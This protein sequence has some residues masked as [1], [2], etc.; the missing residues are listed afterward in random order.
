MTR[1]E[2]DSRGRLEMA[3]LTLYLERGFDHT[4]VAEIAE[5]AGVTE[6]T[7]FRHFADKREVLFSGGATFLTLITSGAA[8]ADEELGPLDAALNGFESV[9]AF[10]Q[11]RRELVLQRH[12][13]IAAN[14]E[15]RE[16]EL[17]KLQALSIAL[18]DT[19]RGRGV[20]ESSAGLIAE[21]AVA[22][23]KS[24][25]EVWVAD[26]ESRELTQ[27]LRQ[28]LSELRSLAAIR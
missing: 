28:S 13:V 14:A 17:I 25:F 16:R 27:V 21:V 9:S 19:L 6:R 8:A 23:F 15:L 26:P 5:R 12:R 4:T 1:W 22:V 10:F 3:A 20:S 2:P 11:D 18:A 24:S 7:F